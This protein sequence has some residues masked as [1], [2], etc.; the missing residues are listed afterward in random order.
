VPGPSLSLNI[1]GT[2]DIGN[3]FEV[4]PIP[5]PSTYF[6]GAPAM[7]VVGYTLRKRISRVLKRA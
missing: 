6:A 1:T 2:L 3:K 5:E 7:T 4:V